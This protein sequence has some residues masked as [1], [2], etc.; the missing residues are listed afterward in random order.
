M[1]APDFWGAPAGLRAWAL[2][3]LAGVYGAAA[4]A[5][6]ARN[7]PRAGVPAIAIGGL[8]LGGDGKTPT[9]LALAS[10][11]ID[12]AERPFFSIR[13]YGRRGSA[14]KEP[15]LV[16]PARHGVLD[17]GDEALLLARTAPTVVGADRL[18]AARLAKSSG[19]TVLLLDDGF[20]SRRIDPDLAFLVVDAHYL[21]GNGFCPPAGPLRAP[22]AAQLARADIL[23]VVGEA[24]G[25]GPM[26]AQSL[27][28]AR[29]VAERESFRLK[30]RKVFAFAGIGRPEK[31]IRTLEEIGVEIAGARWFPD[32]HF[33]SPAEL[34]SLAAA[35][36][37]LGASAVTT[38]KDLVRISEPA[39][40]ES[41]AVK[42]V[43]EERERV[44]EILIEA[45]ALRRGLSRFP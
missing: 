41:L 28:R 14:Q 39:P 17:V 19:A 33:Y 16:D 35:A 34:T 12:A 38:E 1:R 22:I 3:P 42:L 13:G 40:F 5:R 6:L 4:K 30:G 26:P 7:A 10:I 11:L 21:A 20:H 15:F 27:L 36:R 8:T 18:A 23:L 45:L 43:F 9:A 32:H 24:R 44:K 37:G 2:S 25:F 31:F 29:L